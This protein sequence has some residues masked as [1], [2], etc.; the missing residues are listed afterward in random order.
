M[1][2]FSLSCAALLCAV[3]SF[4]AQSTNAPYAA[5][6]VPDIW[7][8]STNRVPVPN[9][10]VLVPRGHTNPY[11]SALSFTYRP[12]I[13]TNQVR[14]PVRVA[15]KTNGVYESDQA[16]AAALDVRFWGIV[17]DNYTDN[18]PALTNLLAYAATNMVEIC[19]PP[20]RYLISKPI[21][22][23]GN[24]PI[25]YRAIGGSFTTGWNSS[26]DI[27]D[28]RL[29]YTGPATNIFVDL[30][31]ATGYTYGVNLE[32][33][34][35][36]ANGLADVAVRIKNSTRGMVDQVR[37]RNSK[38][39]GMVL[40][41]SVF[42]TFN[43]F[44][45][46]ANEVP[47]TTSPSVGLLL[48]N[49]ANANT[50]IGT[51]ISGTTNW[52]VEIVEGA[53]GSIANAF[54]GGGI[55]SNLGGGVHIGQNCSLNSFEDVWF[56][57]NTDTNRFFVLDAGT[58]Q[59]ELSG[60]KFENR[61]GKVYVN[62]SYNVVERSILGQLELGSSAGH[63]RLQDLI[64]DIGQQPYPL[65]YAWNQI[66]NNV[67]DATATLHMNI[68]PDAWAVYGTNI[69]MYDTSTNRPYPMATLARDSILWGDGTRT[70]TAGWTMYSTNSLSTPNTILFLRSGVSDGVFSVYG[71]GDTY[72]RVSLNTDTTYATGPGGTNAVDT[73]FYRMASRTWLSSG[74]WLITRPNTNAAVVASYLDGGANPMW[75][76][77]ANGTLEWGVGGATAMDTTLYRS[78]P[79]TLQ[80]NND[81]TMNGGITLGGVYRTSWPSG[82][83][84][85]EGNGIQVSG[86]NVISTDL[87]AGANITLTT[88]GSGVITIASTGSGGATNG[89]PV[90][91]N[92][93]G[94]LAA[95]NL[96]SST[97]ITVTGSGTNVSF[98]V[99]NSG[100]TPGAYTSANITVGSDGRIISAANGSAGGST[101]ATAV[102]VDGG[103][104]LSA[105]NLQSSTNVSLTTSGTNVTVAVTNS[106]VTA[107]AYT[108]ANITVGADGRIISAA[109]GSAGGGDVYQNGTNTFTGTN[110]FQGKVIVSNGGAGATYA[111]GINLGIAT[112]TETFA[113][114]P[115]SSTA[116][117]TN[118]VALTGGTNT[119]SSQVAIGGAL[120][121]AS[122]I[123]GV[124]TYFAGNQARIA[125]GSLGS[126]TR[127]F[128][129]IGTATNND[130]V[131]IGSG[132]T[133]GVYTNAYAL[134]LNATSTNHNTITLG[135]SSM[136]IISQG[137]FKPASTILLNGTAGSA[138]QILTSTGTGA[139]W[140][141][142]PS[143]TGSTNGTPV[144]VNAG[145]ILAA[146]NLQSTT[147]ITVT[148]T[149]TNITFTVTNSGVT[150]G[151]YNYANVTVGADGRV[152]S[153]STNA[154]TGTGPIVLS[155]NATMSIGT[156]YV[157]TNLFVTDEAY[158]V[159]WDGSTNVP[160]KNAVYD[161]IQSLTPGSGNGTNI[162][163]KGTLLQP[164]QLTNSSKIDWSV[165]GNVA[166]PYVTNLTS[167]D[168]GDG[169][170]LPLTAGLNKQIT[171][172]LSF[173][174]IGSTDHRVGFIEEGKDDSYHA[175]GFRVNAG[176][177][178]IVSMAT[179]D[180]TVFRTFA[181]W[182][183]NYNA[184]FYGN[185]VVSSNL[186]VQGTFTN[187]AIGAKQVTAGTNLIVG[188]TI[189][190][191]GSFGTAGQL[192]T[193]TGTGAAWSNAP[194]AGGSG[195][196]A[197]AA[198]TNASAAY[199]HPGSVFWTPTGAAGSGN[200]QSPWTVFID[201]DFFTDGAGPFFLQGATGSGISTRDTGD[202]AHPGIWTYSTSTSS[203]GVGYMLSG[204][205]ASGILFNGMAWELYMRLKIPTLSDGTETFAVRFGFG[206][207]VTGD[208]TDGAYFQHDN[209]T[210]IWL[211]KTANN[212]SRT[213]A[214]GGTPVT[215]TAGW[216][217]LRISVDST[218]STVTF[219]VWSGGAW[220]S[221]GSSTTNIPKTAGR[222]F[223][224]VGHIVK[225]A[226]T[227][228]RTLSLDKIR[229]IG[230]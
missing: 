146:A 81:L 228:A 50:F 63:N 76:A 229:L 190:A 223:G 99:T 40:E 171:G 113:V 17:G 7:S 220:V 192:L 201:E 84:Y 110:T 66:V 85:T 78:G 74:G 3:S 42:M 5:T 137:P 124:N 155:T 133:T 54:I 2:A 41:N 179:N 159:S 203:T 117:F 26:D 199:A 211:G 222:E 89:T 95:A 82:A 91:V 72:P 20:G 24:F 102:T 166:M 33:I 209:T 86:G 56:E 153:A 60:F 46:S 206:D 90:S 126:G 31:A 10:T 194:A 136:E 167:A 188:G 51:T 140:S 180:F 55:E 178:S 224:V 67:I 43:N 4:G 176:I 230:Y 142:A 217:D 225:S 120:T 65:Y 132:A 93:G 44:S 25:K 213:T 157:T 21:S 48:T 143:I 221:I 98:V 75:Y 197:N 164:A 202:G 105:L 183:T 130:T 186:T 45:C 104:L 191:G 177:F 100:V 195:Q 208:N 30:G 226:G 165:S 69:W 114:G 58:F 39:Y 73:S 123:T 97:N 32:K 200:W 106:G 83:T 53:Q 94:T 169:P 175:T 38:K 14:W 118:A 61:I 79:A 36:D 112:N 147:N 212:S 92:A 119:A 168:L 129:V 207:N 151:V 27:T 108:S 77:R 135:T 57:N 144:S 138:G 127:N 184:N 150:P 149:T 16:Y 18:Y 161:K 189:Q 131:A 121:V 6:I 11:P 59:N 103:A 185:L 111:A 13:S 9:E 215:V 205:N 145:G 193:S 49:A 187:A 198:L 23:S 116:T 214:S 141:N 152:I 128:A 134:G 210:N 87:A 122:T 204:D 163:V 34:T 218:G 15:A 181:D 109:N 125:N 35:F 101:N 80:I 170:F 52:A 64:L 68:M 162:F 156:L 172:F 62:G 154:T 158:G 12:D 19:F 29:I 37:P 227:T 160:T 148:A 1:K 107:G 216:N 219:Y 8:L 28:T 88:N 196:P 70:P 22:T 115:R 182:D 174:K 139:A 173:N 71:P 47:F 96:Q